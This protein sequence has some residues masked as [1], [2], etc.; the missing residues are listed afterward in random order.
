MNTT[1]ENACNVIGM[2]KNAIKS[3]QKEEQKAKMFYNHNLLK[4]QNTA[5]S[6]PAFTKKTKTK[7]TI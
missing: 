6:F 1:G 7:Q 4:N 2:F 5:K 3:T